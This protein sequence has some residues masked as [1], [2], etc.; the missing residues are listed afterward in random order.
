MTYAE[1]VAKLENAVAIWTA[2]V[3]RGGGQVTVFPSQHPRAGQLAARYPVAGGYSYVPAPDA[4]AAARAALIAE[5][6]DDLEQAAKLAAVADAFRRVGE[7]LKDA[8]NLALEA[9][10]AAVGRIFGIPTWLV[11]VLVVGF[12]GAYVWRASRK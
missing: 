2:S 1:Q 9:P 7:W 5:E 8:G 11:T 3:K 12:V 10:R 4:I 6:R